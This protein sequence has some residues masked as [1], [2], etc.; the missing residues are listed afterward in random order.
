[1]ITSILCVGVIVTDIERS[2]V[3]Y[4]DTLGLSF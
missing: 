3:F 1:M 4:R 2:S